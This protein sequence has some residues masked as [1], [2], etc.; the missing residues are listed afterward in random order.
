MTRGA[1]CVGLIR[2]H[3]IRRKVALGEICRR[4]RARALRR[5]LG[6]LLGVDVE[7]DA[8]GAKPRDKI[9]F[10]DIVVVVV[11]IIF[12]LSRGAEVT[13]HKRRTVVEAF[14]IFFW[15]WEKFFFFVV[16]RRGRRGGGAP[17]G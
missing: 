7:L 11:V 9:S 6:A 17:Y 1:R 15:W 8:P 3:R 2:T 10:V 13:K 12:T 5:D 16:L 14:F 4:Q